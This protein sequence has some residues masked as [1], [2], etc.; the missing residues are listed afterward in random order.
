MT[1]LGVDRGLNTLLS[2]EAARLH[3]DGTITVLDSG[4]MFRAAGIL[5][6]QHRLR[7]LSEHLYTKADHYQ[8]L[9]AGVDAHYPT[10]K[11]AMLAEEIRHV[12]DRRSNLDDA[13]AGAAARWAVDQ[14]ITAGAPDRPTT[15]GWEWALCGSCGWQ[16]DR[17]SG[18]CKRNRRTRPYPPVQDCRGPRQRGHDDPL[19]DRQTRSGRGHHT[20]RAEDQ[21]RPVQDRTHPATLSMSDAQATPDTLP[22]QA[23]GSGGPASGGTRSHGPDP[24]ASRSRSAPGRDD[25]QHTHH[26]PPQATRSSTGRGLP[27]AR[28]RDSSAM[29]NPVARHY[30]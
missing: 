8:R 5:A 7:R 6:K 30:V 2:A 23:F 16:G 27:P 17:D 12:S 24:V 28:P 21:P 10:G 25:D 18:T 4:G 19:G 26:R 22:H 1:A 13:L 20:G 11:L 9:T 3:D 14:A 15:P 29:G